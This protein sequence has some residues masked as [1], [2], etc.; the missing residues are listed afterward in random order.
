M[1]LL[2]TGLGRLLKEIALYR[3]FT[4]IMLVLCSTGAVAAQE[5]AAPKG[6]PIV[7][8]KTCAPAFARFCPELAETHR[9]RDQV[10]C[11]K[12]YRLSLSLPCRR[13]V[14]A[15]LAAQAGPR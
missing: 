9:L 10:I 13:A 5:F 7:L 2:P 8:D 11:L 3:C 15:A 6:R 14:T 4:A 1:A 12:P